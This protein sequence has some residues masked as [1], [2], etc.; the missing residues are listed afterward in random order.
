MCAHGLTMH[1]KCSNY[2]LTNLLFNLCRFVWII[3]ALITLPN[4]HLGAPTCP[5][6]PKMLQAKGHTPTPSIVFIFRLAFESFKESGGAS[7]GIRTPIGNHVHRSGPIP[8]FIKYVFQWSFEHFATT[9]STQGFY[10]PKLDFAFSINNSSNS[11]NLL[12][13]LTSIMVLGLFNY[14]LIVSN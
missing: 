12:F 1:Q 3:Y 7:R 4:P 6:T 11:F 8:C 13:I 10:L 9:P 5:S 14:T 2:T